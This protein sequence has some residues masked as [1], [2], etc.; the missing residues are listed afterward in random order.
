MI[1]IEDQGVVRVLR[2]QHGKANALDLEFCLGLETAIQELVASPMR[3]AV[4]TGTG[5]IFSAGVDLKRLLDGGDTYI[6]DFMDALER[7]FTAIAFC[8]KPLIAAANGHAI[9]G[10]SILLCACDRRLIA[11]G[12][13]RFGVPELLVGVPFP[14]VALEIL[15]AAVS[16]KDLPRIIYEGSTMRGPDAIACGLADEIIPSEQLLQT[17][18]DTAQRLAKIPANSFRATKRHLR[19]PLR[20]RMVTQQ[21]AEKE[22][23]AVWT[24]PE[25]IAAIRAFIATTLS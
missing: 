18:I 2:M 5:K 15:R 20:E 21:D 25:T 1:Q 16:P 8:S 22:L 7:A 6:A 10:G 3:A 9:A 23:R 17:S 12:Q 19:A 11:E 4:L 24:E 13:A 14:L